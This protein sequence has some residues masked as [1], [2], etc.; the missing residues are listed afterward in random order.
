MS[1]HNC[2]GKWLKLSCAPEP[3]KMM[4]RVIKVVVKSPP[5]F[6]NFDHSLEGRPSIRCHVKYG[7]EIQWNFGKLLWTLSQCRY[8]VLKFI[9]DLLRCNTAVLLQS[10]NRVCKVPSAWC[11]VGAELRARVWI[12]ERLPTEGAPHVDN[13]QHHLN[14]SSS[15][16]RRR[17]IIKK[18]FH[19][20][21]QACHGD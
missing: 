1:E 3:D 7:G 4:A 6:L 9:L 18:I 14:W 17:R 5:G 21:K 10:R 8:E 15:S 2:E 12:Y 11:K 19:K 20:I 13:L 16:R